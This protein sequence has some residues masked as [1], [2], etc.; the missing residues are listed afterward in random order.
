MSGRGGSDA[1]RLASV[2]V[3]SDVLGCCVGL[4]CA[5]RSSFSRCKSVVLPALSR[6][7][8]KIFAFLC[9]RPA[10]HARGISDHEKPEASRE[11]RASERANERA[12]ERASAAQ[13]NPSGCTRARG[14]PRQASTLQGAHLARRKFPQVTPHNW[15]GGVLRGGGGGSREGASTAYLARTKSPQHIPDPREHPHPWPPSVQQRLPAG[16]PINE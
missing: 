15:G 3:P 10:E 4:C 8:N 2:C 14:S 1:V 7:R 12:S 6:P 9:A 5:M 16:L 11:H 13:L